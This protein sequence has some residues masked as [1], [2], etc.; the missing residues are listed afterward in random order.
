MNRDFWRFWIGETISAFGSSFTQFAIP[1]L[2]FKLTG[3]AIYLAASAALFTVPHLL[4]GLLIGAWTD[5]TDRRRLM[6]VTDILNMAAVG[7][8][9]VAAVAGVLS[10]WWILAVVFVTSTLGIFFEAAAF[11]AIPSLVE[12]ADLVT[13]NGRIQ[14]T[15]A[16]AS[17]LGP[18]VA[19][20]LLVVLPVDQLLVVDAATFVVS[21]VALSLIRRPFNAPLARR[22]TTIR[23]DVVEGLR[24]VLRHPVLRNISAMMALVNLVSVTAFAQ[25]VLLAKERYAATDSEI[26]LLF[27]AGGV[28]VVLFSLAAG[29]LRKRWSFGNVALG[30]LMASGLLTIGLAYAPTYLV[31]VACWGLSSG[32]GTM[33]NINTGSLRQAIVPNQMLGR[34]ITIAMVLAW[35]A[36]PI[37]AIGGGFAVERT[38]D[39][40]LVYAVVG[41]LTFLIPL[42]FRLFS[43]L[44]HAERYLDTPARSVQ[45]LP[46][47]GA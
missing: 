20:A 18:L 8:V 13:A 34:I 12:Q 26:G 24:Y 11:G 25:L 9:P 36:N 5:R 33:F 40:Q 23:Q 1:L 2:V 7:S 16:G 38:H 27:A 4:F 3:S 46:A 35:S 44:G 42:Y 14:A 37:G 21:A 22:A 31:A 41:V 19:G 29:P 30:A 43:P 17:V 39:V 15:F 6:I 47:D 32:L 28:G 10:V 45:A